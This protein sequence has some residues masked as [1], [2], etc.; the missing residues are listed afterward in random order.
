[1]SNFWPRLF[2]NLGMLALFTTA[3][4]DAAP[5]AVD[6]SVDLRFEAPGRV[7]AMT[8]QPDGKWIVGGTFT[9]VNG[10]DRG[11]IARL[12]PDG[13]LDPTFD[14]GPKNPDVFDRSEV[15]DIS[16]QGEKVLVAGSLSHLAGQ[17]ASAVVRLNANGTRDTTFNPPVFAS[18]FG[19]T[20]WVATDRGDGK[21]LVGGGFSTVG[22]QARAN[23][24]RLDSLGGI[25]STFNPAVNGTV[26]SALP[27]SGDRWLIGGSF[28]T[29]SG[30]SRIGIARIQANGAIDTS[31]AS[32]PLAS[33]SS[34]RSMSVQPDGKI[35]YAGS[36]GTARFV[37]RALPDG[38][39]DP[40]FSPA[41]APGFFA[42][43]LL[44][45]D[46]DIM[47]NGPSGPFEGA[48]G[49]LVTR[50]QSNGSIAP[51]AQTF[52]SG[53]IYQLAAVDSGSVMLG[54]SF[55][56]AAGLPRMAVAKLLSN[57]T[58]DPGFQPVVADPSE[59][60]RIIPLN[61]GQ[62]LL[63]GGFR[64]SGDGG[65]TV[66]YSSLSRLTPSL[67]LDPDFV[68]PSVSSISGPLVT[69]EAPDG[70]LVIA[71]QWGNQIV[72]LG[73][74][75]VVDPGFAVSGT[76]T[77][78]DLLVQS[79]GRILAAGAVSVL[80]GISQRSVFR[81]LP[82][83][84]LDQSFNPP[85]TVS[86]NDITLEIGGRIL[87]A[88]DSTLRRLQP[89]GLTD[90][91]F[92]QALPLTGAIRAVA[93]LPG[94]RVLVAG[95][96][97]AL[98]GQPAVRIARLN[99]T[100]NPDPTFQPGSGADGQITSLR[101][102]SDGDIFIAGEFTT[103]NGQ[104]RKGIAQLSPDGALR[105]AFD[106]G[107][108]FDGAVRDL[109]L[110]ADGNVLA[111]GNFSR[112]G[113]LSS[114]G[115]AKLEAAPLQSIPP[116]PTSPG[117]PNA[118]ALSSQKVLLIWSDS[119]GE[120]GYRVERRES[121]SQDWL[122]MATPAAGSTFYSDET[123]V[124]GKSYEYRVL[125]WNSSGD[126]PLAVAPLTSVPTRAGLAGSQV[127]GDSLDLWDAGEIRAVTR[128]ADG[129]FVI[130]GTFTHVNGTPRARMAR[131]TASGELDTSF[132]PDA[133]ILGSQVSIQTLAVQ[134]SGRIIVG[135]FNGLI[136]L[137]PDGAIDPAFT[138]PSSFSTVYEL[139]VLPDD[140]LLV[141]GAFSGGTRPYLARTSANG[142]IDVTFAN[143]GLNGEVDA[144]AVLPD[145]KILVSGGFTRAG[146]VTTSVARF[147]SNGTLDTSFAPVTLA[148][149]PGA[150][151]GGLG[152]TMALQSDGKILVGGYF[153]SVNNQPRNSLVR[154]ESNG[155]VDTSFVS[156]SSPND[157]LHY[158]GLLADGKVMIGGQFESHGGTPR[159]SWA[160]LSPTGA[161][162]PGNAEI[163][164]GYVRRGVKL[165]GGRILVVGRFWT[166]G[167][168]PHFGLVR[169][170]ADASTVDGTFSPHVARAGTV[171]A[172]TR[173]P[174]GNALVLGNF[175]S[176][177]GMPPSGIL[178]PTIFR[179]EPDG[180]IDD[181]FDAGSGFNTAPFV[182]ATGPGG[183]IFVGGDFQSV[184]GVPRA[185]VAAL[186]SNGAID[187]AFNPGTGANQIVYTI[188][189]ESGG[190]AT[191]GG[192]FSTVNGLSRPRIAR[193][194]ETGSVTGDFGGTVSPS[195]GAN[196]LSGISQEDG[197][198]WF[199]GSFTTLNGNPR[200][201]LAKQQ[202]NG[203]TAATDTAPLDGQVRALIPQ[204]G[205]RFFAGGNFTT[206]SGVPRARVARLTSTGALDPTFVPQLA[207]SAAAPSTFAAFAADEAGRLYVAGTWQGSTPLRTLGL[208]RLSSDGSL[209][210]TFDTG[211]AGSGVT[212]LAV[213]NGGL[214]AGGSFTS[215]NDQPRYGLVRLHVQPS[216]TTPHAPASLIATGEESG[217]AL[218]WDEVPNASG[219]VIEKR[220]VSSSTWIPVA[221]HLP[222]ALAFHDSS[223]PRGSL[224][225]YRILA[226]NSAGSSP[227]SPEVDLVLPT[228]FS[229]WKADRGIAAGTPDDD[230]SDRDGIP[231]F[232]EYSLAL[233]PAS[234][235][236][237]GLPGMTRNGEIIEFSYLHARADVDYVVEAS[238]DL[239]HWSSEGVAQGEPTLHRTATLSANGN[240]RRFLRLAVHASP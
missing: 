232:L 175:A 227:S 129:K 85:S 144:I 128:Q 4:L 146:F 103:F 180:S 161:L 114:A 49:D 69:A 178:R 91:G 176:V 120:S 106:P 74:N 205:L 141:G 57:G 217:V 28:T 26:L 10:V 231:L 150:F 8:V 24:V 216:L 15:Y 202:A 186:H 46:G 133:A 235:D 182:A 148:P 184:N 1:M 123:V 224:W 9:S 56:K 190:G 206:V 59:V 126:A 137:A 100:G 34:I 50:L 172:I 136:G 108:A 5:G 116:P 142:V 19:P 168:V 7:S 211:S 158:V 16:L 44:L 203:S 17:P 45:P 237:Q 236:R 61:G 169:L 197:A 33:G 55:S 230:D 174:D 238:G 135:S 93:S 199:G 219:Y 53:S 167:G 67:G 198:R 160:V 79:D 73:V 179:I 213:I 223:S 157:F 39:A 107:D 115:F 147:N 92:N 14:P 43:S 127:A 25:D 21:V 51:V 121:G 76:F 210:R 77:L 229:Y 212:D 64:N 159:A 239:I 173:Q 99:A 207:T 6:T 12:N 234:P 171:A 131:L 228:T 221:T 110:D 88:G 166:A 111:V 163:R 62:W 48:S 38:G 66:T 65:G 214:L 104:P 215:W 154:L 195:S 194:D 35:V 90:P 42:K 109:A 196:V 29:V 189:P 233:S 209:D 165:P 32:V 63:T 240:P 208:L 98:G 134:S 94:H 101:V 204:P 187:P 68:P 113:T 151:T 13:S 220:E 80:N 3:R 183:R 185:R 218:S 40:A 70:S 152:T 11:K 156:G 200:A 41:A 75:G 125:A 153:A 118:T 81:L 192:A 58:V 119:S 95:N 124:P 138:P 23:L 97:T 170:E 191:I 149:P 225:T 89:S 130:A 78:A 164:S 162:D 86:L 22:G 145:G 27:V 60:R 132:V 122:T 36:L 87:I 18:S 54:G 222:G 31:F 96:F 140:R 177:G 117:N 72:R 226:F 193:L 139:V 71:N 20:A 52:V 105:Q 82:D 188:V 102:R 155:A 47:I 83:G 30:Q 37:G 112:A 84:A 181:G 2:L 201:Y 143:A